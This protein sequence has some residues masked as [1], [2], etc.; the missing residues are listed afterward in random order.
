M[1]FDEIL[2]E[3]LR[4]KLAHRKNVQEK[5]MFGGLGFLLKGNMLVGIWKEALIVRLGIEEFEDA[6]MQPHA[7]VFNITGKTM[8]GWVMVDPPGVIED[9]QLDYWIQQAWKFV[10]KMP[11]K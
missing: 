5:N 4:E 6:L 3:R 8:R 1:P 7:R 2:A 11:A 9:E 10:A